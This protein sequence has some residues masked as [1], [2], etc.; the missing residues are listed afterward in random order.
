MSQSALNETSNPFDDFFVNPVY[1]QFKKR[2]Y[3]IS[4]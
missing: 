3:P 4:S 1:L 2:G